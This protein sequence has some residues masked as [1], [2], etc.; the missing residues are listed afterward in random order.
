MLSRAPL[1]ARQIR[2]VRFQTIGPV[3]E[4]PLEA[5]LLAV[6]FGRVCALPIDAASGIGGFLDSS[7]RLIF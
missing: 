6:F 7:R 5:V 3:E 1:R 2:D 4:Y